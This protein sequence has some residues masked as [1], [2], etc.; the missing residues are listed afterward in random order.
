MDINYNNLIIERRGEIATVSFNRPNRANVL[1]YDSIY[2]QSKEKSLVSGNK[3]IC[4]KR[5]INTCMQKDICEVPWDEWGVEF[6]VD[7]S[8]I[9]EN[10]FKAE[11]LLRNRFK[12]RILFTNS[13]EKIDFTMILGVNENK[14]DPRVTQGSPWGYP[15][16]TPGGTLGYLFLLFFFLI[17]L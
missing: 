10:T 5:S 15:L 14:F 7:S 9:L 2:G 8:G 6:I 1:N 4:N 16:G 3:L 13:P 17:T 12:K 11:N